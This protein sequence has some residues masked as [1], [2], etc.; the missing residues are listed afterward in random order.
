MFRSFKYKLYPTKSQTPLLNKHIG[1][2]RFMYNLALET[3]QMAWNLARL[4]IRPYELYGQIQELRSEYTWLKDVSVEALRSPITH[5]DDAY[6]NFF[7]GNASSPKFKKKTHVGSFTVCQGTT[8]R[9]NRLHIV[10][11]KEGIPV[12]LHRPL[13]GK[14]KQATITKTP[15]GKFFVSILCETGEECKPKSKV[16]KQNTI[17]I[18]LGLKTF[19]V[20]SNGDEYDNPKFLKKAQS[21][22]KYT[23]RKFSKHK[24][25]RTKSKLAKLHEKVANQR[26]DFLH[27]VSTKLIRENQSIAVENL[28]VNNMLKNRNLAGAISDVS[29]GIFKEFL[30]YKAE[31]HGVNILEI[32]TFEPS[33]KL[34]S[35]CGYLNMDLKLSDR[36]WICPKCKELVPRDLNAAVNIK[37][38]ALKNVSGAETKTRNE[39]LALA[40]VMT[41]ETH[42]GQ[43][44]AAPTF[45]TKL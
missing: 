4:Y 35:K 18:D 10:K 28:K 43:L 6:T 24:G 34:H 31:W 39:L 5:L 37:N 38:F 8:I 30:K 42:I 27:K 3:Q 11:F 33:S 7:Q 19:I 29:W 32:G 9:K 13:Q 26:K 1:C 21:K 36:G 16:T 22:L 23:Q 40:G 2:A 25:K 20:S 15:T 12:I 45:K 41:S 44:T 14:I 17:G